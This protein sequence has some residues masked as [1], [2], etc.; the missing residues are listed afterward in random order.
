[1]ILVED[2]MERIGELEEEIQ[3]IKEGGV[4]SKPT[5]DNGPGATPE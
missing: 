2:K 4:N 3:S 5:D 1:M